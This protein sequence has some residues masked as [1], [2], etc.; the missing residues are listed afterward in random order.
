[1]KVMYARAKNQ[2]LLSH[3]LCYESYVITVL[4]HYSV[5]SVNGNRYRWVL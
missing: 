1:M 5:L 4:S 3:R 2:G